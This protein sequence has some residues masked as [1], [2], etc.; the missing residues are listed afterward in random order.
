MA[1]PSASLPLIQLIIQPNSPIFPLPL[2]LFPGAMLPL[3]ISKSRDRIMMNNLLQTET[4]QRFGVLFSNSNPTDPS[5]ASVEVEIGCVAE[6][7]NHQILRDDR[8]YLIC[9]GQ[10]RF[11]ISDILRTE[12]YMV[13]A[14]NWLEDGPP[15]D[16]AQG[17]DIEKLASEVEDYMKDIMRISNRLEG[18]KQDNQKVDVDIRKGQFPTPFSFYVASFF[19]SPTEQQLEDA[20]TRLKRERDTLKSTLNLLTDASALL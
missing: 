17:N 15:P 2:V 10:E 13:A 11:R 6:V 5:S 14:I 8:F 16:P 12:P 20:V 7:V 9:K 4:D 3:Y 18:K 1:F 19:N